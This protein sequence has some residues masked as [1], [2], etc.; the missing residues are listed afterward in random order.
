[1]HRPRPPI[2]RRIPAWLLVLL[3]LLAASVISQRV[4]ADP[5]PSH[6]HVATAEPRLIRLMTG[7]GAA[8]TLVFDRPV[9]HA[10]SRITL[11]L[12]DGSARAVPVRLM[13]QPSAV[14][15]ALGR[16]PAGEYRLAWR[17]QPSGGE[18]ISGQASFTVS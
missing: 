9:S 3:A 2:R 10:G 15:V 4:Q 8:F 14:Y 13:A 7:P 17:V 5:P 11:I 12:P 1:M 6:A 16:L 18:P